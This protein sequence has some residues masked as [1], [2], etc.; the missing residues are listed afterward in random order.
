MKKTAALIL[1]IFIFL[2]AFSPMSFAA[3]ESNAY[4]S[5]YGCGISKPSSNTVRIDFYVIATN[6]MDSLGASTIYLYRDGSLVK[7]FSR[8][9]FQYT[10][11]M[12]TT[13][14]YNFFG[15][16]TYTNAPE[17][18]YYAVVNVFASDGTGTGTEGC[19][20]GSITIP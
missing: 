19:T 9:N 16:V 5:E 7:T 17:G 15:H 3:T 18:T 2:Q 6:N 4:I 13:N 11:S 20:T 12:V 14:N 1:C 10:A 8:Y